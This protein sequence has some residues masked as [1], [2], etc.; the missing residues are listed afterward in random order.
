M[1]FN[2]RKGLAL[3]L[4]LVLVLCMAPVSVFADGETPAYADGTYKVTGISSSLSMFNKLIV[5][6]SCKVVIKDGT[7][8]LVLVTNSD[9]RYNEIMLGKYAD[10]IKTGNEEGFKGFYND[11]TGE[12]GVKGLTYV[13]PLE[14]SES[15]LSFPEGGSVLYVILRYKKGYDDEHDGIWYKPKNDVTVTVTGIE[16][17]SDD[18]TLPTGVYAADALEA[19]SVDAL[20]DAIGTVTLE[21]EEAIVAARTAYDALTDAQKALVTK[22]ETLTAAE[23]KLKELKDAQTAEQ[24]AANVDAL[25]AAIGEVTLESEEK[26]TAARKAYDALTDDQ[27]ALVTKLETLTAAEA[28]L[29]ELKD[30]QAAAQEAAHTPLTVTNKVGMFKV[31]D[32]SAFL[33][34]A[35]DGS[36]TLVFALNGSGYSNLFK[37]TYEEAKANGA[38]KTKW[39]VGEKNAAG[40]LEFKMPVKD[41]ETYIPVVAI[42]NS[43]LEKY[44]A[45]QNPIERAFFPRQFTLDATAKTLLVEDYSSSKDLEIVNEVKMFKPTGAKLTTV[46]GPNSNDY[47]TTLA[48]AYGSASFDKAFI[49]NASDAGSDK[50]TVVNFADGAFVFKLRWMA[51]KGDP[52][53]VVNLMEEPFTVSFHSVKNDSWYERVFTVSEDKGTLTITE[54]TK[55]DEDAVVKVVSVKDKNGKTV[56]FTLGDVA[57]ENELTKPIAVKVNAKVENEES[58][59]I[60]WQKDLKVPAGTEFPVTVEFE[61]KNKDENFY[62]YHF[63][64]TAWE[65]VGEGKGGKATVTFDKLS[66]TGL[67]AVNN[68]NTGDASELYLWAGA[69]V[70]FAAAAVVIAGRRRKEEK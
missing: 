2:A 62:M 49:G 37:G 23:A 65:V 64:G 32:G 53:S 46:G 55:Q 12:G 47:A 7:A 41:G 61:Y 67:V 56:A 5:A 16:K 19:A 31:V 3:L 25:I 69:F 36:K 13:I 48:L 8:T 15:F 43:Y 11:I 35:E 24:A 59:N 63:N 4:A 45:G 28:K 38:D 14:D 44:E 26:I 20:I 10:K 51:T 54:A 52:T 39:L 50:V 6:G 42:S 40:K 58:I 22:L 60:E 27:K 29:K 57:K 18:T 30:A 70:V 68:P 1:K 66:P 21:S 34:T 9:A 33:D 17:E